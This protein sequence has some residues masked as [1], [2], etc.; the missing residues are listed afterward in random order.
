MLPSLLPLASIAVGHLS[1]TRY[2]NPA[3]TIAENKVLTHSL[4]G[5]NLFS[6]ASFIKQFVYNSIVRG[7]KVIKIKYVNIGRRAAGTN[8]GS[9][10]KIG[11]VK[12]SKN[13]I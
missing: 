4:L 3:L 9:L 2:M 10:N 11:I 7:W 6:T 5:E 8:I 1:D 13:K 12:N